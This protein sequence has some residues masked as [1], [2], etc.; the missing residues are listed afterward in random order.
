MVGEGRVSL[1]HIP[2][3]VFLHSY[4]KRGYKLISKQSYSI[5]ENLMTAH[6]ALMKFEAYQSPEK[7]NHQNFRLLWGS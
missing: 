1:T 2:V 6:V 4:R 5:F 7:C 3:G